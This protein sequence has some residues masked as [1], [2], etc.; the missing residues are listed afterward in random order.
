MNADVRSYKRVFE[1]CVEI[2]F[3][4][5]YERTAKAVY[6]NLLLR[7]VRKLGSNNVMREQRSPFIQKGFREKCGKQVQTRL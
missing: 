7:K 2:R 1:K 5:V 4:Q 6:S 3:K